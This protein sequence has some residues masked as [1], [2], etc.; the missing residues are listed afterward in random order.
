MHLRRVVTSYADYYNSVRTHRSLNKDPPIS[1]PVQRTGVINS[2]PILGVGG[3]FGDK[4]MVAL[5]LMVFAMFIWCEIVSDV[6]TREVVSFA[7]SASRTSSGSE[8]LLPKL[9]I[10]GSRPGWLLEVDRSR[11]DAWVVPDPA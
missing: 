8:A 2:R 5:L 4:T 1:R 3:D 10:S 11:L 6:S 7:I 9:E